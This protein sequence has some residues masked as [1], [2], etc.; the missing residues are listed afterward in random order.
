MVQLW[1]MQ[2][3]VAWHDTFAI[4][5]KW[6]IVFFVHKMVELNLYLYILQGQP[7]FD[8]LEYII[9]FLLELD[10]RYEGAATSICHFEHVDFLG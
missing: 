10:T 7:C 6:L 8:I 2:I 5:P 4:R 3:A 9:C 1:K